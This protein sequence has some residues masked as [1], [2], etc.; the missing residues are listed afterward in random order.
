MVDLDQLTLQANDGIIVEDNHVVARLVGLVPDLLRALK[1]VA[2]HD[3]D[4]LA[5]Y[6]AVCE[7]LNHL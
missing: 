3:P 7:E 1:S 5:R 4:A 2:H 6:H